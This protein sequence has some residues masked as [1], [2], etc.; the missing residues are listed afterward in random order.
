MKILKKCKNVFLCTCMMVLVLSF[1]VL[2]EEDTQLNDTVLDNSKEYIYEMTLDNDEYTYSGEEIT[3]DVTISVYDDSVLVENTGLVEGV[4]YELEYLN[5]KNAGTAE[6]KVKGLGDF[7]GILDLSKEFKILRASINNAEVSLSANMY[8]Y[9]GKVK[10]PAV[11]VKVNGIKLSSSDDYSLAYANN[12]EVGKNAK[13][14]ITGKGNYTGKVTKTFQIKLAKPDFSLS[15][16]YNEIGISIEKVTGATGYRIYRSE[17]PKSDYERIATIKTTKNASYT[18][19]GL[20]HNKKYYYK[21]RAYRVVNGK[22][23]YSDYTG[24]KYRLTRVEAPVLEK[25]SKKNYNTLT[26]SWDRVEGATGYRVYRSKSK[27]GE[28]ERIA[29]LNGNENLSYD[30]TGLVCGRRYYYKV[31]AYRTENGTK[32][33]GSYSNVKYNNTRPAKTKITGESLY[34]SKKVTLRWEKASVASGYEIYR[35]TS[36]NGTYKLV[37]TITSSKTLEWTN[38]GLTKGKI[39]YYKIRAYRE[40]DGRKVYGLYSAVFKKEKAG[41]KYTTSDGRKVKLYYNSKG[42]LVTDVSQLIGKQDSYVIRVNKQRCTV[43]VYAKDGKNGYIIPVRSFVCSPGATTPTGTFYTPAKYRWHELMGPCW[44]QWNTRIVDG[45]L[46]HSVFYNS[47]QNNNALSVSAYNKLGTICSHG[48]VRLT[49]GDAKWIYDNCDL[50]TKVII[51]NSSISGPFGKPSAY[52]LPYWH[53]WDPTDPN[54]FDKCDS[55]GCH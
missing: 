18:D 39:Y 15:R 7:E 55:Y 35:A 24:Y 40:I 2:A 49:A 54:K 26:I 30:N 22:T 41:W 4:D 3:P 37:K 42:E 19:T 43:T 38:T 14:T 6:V 23:Y 11:T 34:D 1:T 5:N 52:K 44:G 53:T 8:T 46:F 51:Y 27:N 16:A 31:R 50:G 9:D 20:S 12:K 13:V 28:Y 29:T 33:Q 48:C 32:Y 17:N 21:V 45:F 25:V 10:K 47:F 36:K